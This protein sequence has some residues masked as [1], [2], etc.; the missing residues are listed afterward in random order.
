V[1]ADTAAAILN[2]GPHRDTAIQLLV[3]VGTNAEIVLGNSERLFACSSPTGPAFEG[4][5][6]SSG[7]RATAGAIERVRIDPETLEPRLRVIGTEKWS[8]E[9]GFGHD[10]RDSGITGICGSGIIEAI[11]EM[12]SAGIIDQ[13]GVIRGELAASS[14]R[15]VADG[16]TFDYELKCDDALGPAIRVTQA[17]VRAIQ[18]AK[19]A[20]KAGI[21][22]LLEHAEL[23][24]VDEIRL[25]GAFGAHIDPAH[26]IV[27]GLIPDI[28]VDQVRAVGNAAGSGAARLL[29]SASQRT[30]VESVVDD[31]TKIET[32]TEP[33][34]QELFV[35]ALAFPHLT[36]ST[37]NLSMHVKL[38]ERSSANDGKPRRRRRTAN[39]AT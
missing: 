22:L 36:G 30:E 1:G 21:D 29:L 16:R 4:A 27:V 17:D 14:E 37:T 8:D 32:A 24:T 39:R 7:Q 20:L 15:I 33:R 35:A 23:A 31:V 13:S 34:F 19:A 3:D 28:P 6:I 9:V 38:P 10:I 2:E 12:V 26:A 5:Q 18:L 11:S 25:A